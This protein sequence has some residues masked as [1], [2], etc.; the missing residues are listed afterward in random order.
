M[1]HMDMDRAD[2][3]VGLPDS[4]CIPPF[5]HGNKQH[6]R[7]EL[8]MKRMIHS[9]WFE[10]QFTVRALEPSKSQDEQYQ[11]SILLGGTSIDKTGF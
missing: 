4:E 1:D 3:T 7:T 2:R 6:I 5:E 11:K 8:N 9:P 10:L